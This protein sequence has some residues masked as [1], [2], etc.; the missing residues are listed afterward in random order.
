[1][2]KLGIYIIL[3][4]LSVNTLVAAGFTVQKPQETEFFAY[5]QNYLIQTYKYT[6]KIKQ[7]W[8]SV[9]YTTSKKWVGYNKDLTQKQVIDFENN[10]IAL[11]TITTSSENAKLQFPILLKDLY[12]K[13]LQEALQNDPI[14]TDT[15]TK[16]TQNEKIELID[17][18]DEDI[19]NELEKQLEESPLIK[20]THKDHTIYKTKLKLPKRSI[21]KKA[22]RYY[23]IVQKYSQKYN[24]NANLIYSII[25]SESD[26]N[27]LARS[28][29]PAYGLMQIV[30]QSAGMD[31]YKF[32]Y[33]KNRVPNSQYLYNP[34]NNIKLGSA[35]LHLLY[36][37]I[38]KDVPNELSRMYL[39]IAAYNSGAG[40]VSKAFVDSTNVKK[41]IQLINI[42]EPQMVF[43]K[44]IQ[45]LPYNETKRYLEKV[46][47]KL[48]QYAQLL[49]SDFVL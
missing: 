24:I 36:F 47:S 43:N 45:D 38:F 6:K 13:S 15:K 25:H 17:L 42:M 33:K 2:K 3:F 37:Y 19:Q 29:A 8:D 5:K 9:E 22:K 27:P 20:V 34:D 41:A 31:A 30:P 12:N 46:T 28:T 40:N 7:K 48:D 39:T 35:Y 44:L 1:M 11:E 16:Q 23:E 32:V 49:K 4:V 18:Q 10:T 14:D 21:I 26:F